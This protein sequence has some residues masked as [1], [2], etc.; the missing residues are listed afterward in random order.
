MSGVQTGAFL[1]LRHGGVG[2]TDIL[3]TAVEIDALPAGPAQRG[4]EMFADAA[5]GYALFRKQNGVIPRDLVDEF[6]CKGIDL[7]KLV[8]VAGDVFFPRSC[9]AASTSSTSSA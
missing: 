3:H 6:I 4:F 5:A 1:D 9:A 8:Y 7:Y 2:Q